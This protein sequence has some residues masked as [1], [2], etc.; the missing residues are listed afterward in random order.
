MYRSQSGYY[1]D[2]IAEAAALWESLAQNHSFIDGNKRVAFA[3]TYT[4]LLIN[5]R[6]IVADEAA[7]YDF[8]IGLY[9]TNSFEFR[10][11]E[12]WLRTHTRSVEGLC[13]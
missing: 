12:P 3:A 9:E 7:T 1:V 2:I 4:F 6:E 11:L 5:G 8:I 10:H 13:H